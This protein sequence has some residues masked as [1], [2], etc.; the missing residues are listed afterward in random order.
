MILQNRVV[1]F[2]KKKKL[3]EVKDPEMGL[4]SILT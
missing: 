1:V 4:L 3:Q 2:K